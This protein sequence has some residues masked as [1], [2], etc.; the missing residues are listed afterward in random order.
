MENARLIK[1]AE[2]VVCEGLGIKISS[3]DS[4]V[5]V[6]NLECQ[7]VKYLTLSVSES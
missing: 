3:F 2:N 7:S 4:Y 5:S 6:S 1:V